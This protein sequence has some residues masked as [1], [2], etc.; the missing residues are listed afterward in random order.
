MILYAR[1]VAKSQQADARRASTGPATPPPRDAPDPAPAFPLEEEHDPL[2]EILESLDTKA[3]VSVERT[4]PAYAKGWLG[5]IE[6]PSGSEGE[7]LECVKAAYGGGT[8]NLR[9]K[10]QRADGRRVYVHGVAH[11]TIAGQPLTD[12]QAIGANGAPVQPAPQTQVQYLPAPATANSDIT[13]AL[14]N[15]LQQRQQQGAPP[16]QGIPELVSALNSAA[17][18]PAPDPLAGIERT[19]G[20]LSKF[21]TLFGDHGPSESGD[22]LPTGSM[23]GIDDT[24]LLMMLMGNQQAQAQP[25]PGAPWGNPTPPPP[26]PG[27]YHWNGTAY[28]WRIG[29][30]PPPPPPNGTPIPNPAQPPAPQAQ[31]QPQPQPQADD[32]DDEPYTPDDVLAGVRDLT[33]AQ[34]ME[35][36][37]RLGE[38]L[39][40]NL[41]AAMQGQIGNVINLGGTKT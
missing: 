10:K 22:G 41:A 17:H 4:A 25:P 12:G 40:E 13:N 16:L 32:D 36:L 23:G 35:V 3:R 18:P 31:A 9:L 34:K 39:P 1:T 6:V 5:D 30:P 11:V 14:I 15:L 24:K 21:R 33:D 20:M 7:L 19:I 2:A 27:H 29:P 37:A 38:V 28:E 26:P 8:Y